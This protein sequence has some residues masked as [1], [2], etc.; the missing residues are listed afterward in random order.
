MVPSCKLHQALL[1]QIT[2]LES[3][4]TLVPF[5]QLHKA[6]T[7]KSLKQKKTRKWAKETRWEMRVVIPVSSTP[8]LSFT[9]KHHNRSEAG[10]QTIYFDEVLFLGS[11]TTRSR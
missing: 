1:I 2:G 11:F 3:L 6:D 10:Q 5:S 4:L 8:T 7:R 9:N